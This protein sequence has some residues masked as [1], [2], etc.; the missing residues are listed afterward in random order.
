VHKS[1]GSE[2]SHT[3]LVL[4][5]RAAS[6]LTRELFY[7]GITRARTAFT[8]IAEKS[9]L[10]EAAVARATQRASAWQGAGQGQHETGRDIAN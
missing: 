6:V 3:V 1:Q 2:F 9:G 4:P 8:L 5:V 7:T 10:L